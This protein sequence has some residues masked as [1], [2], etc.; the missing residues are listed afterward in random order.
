MDAKAATST[1]LHPTTKTLRFSGTT[2][3]FR[4]Q[5]LLGRTPKRYPC[6]GLWGV[7][8]VLSLNAPQITP[9]ICPKQPHSRLKMPPSRPKPP[10]HRSSAFCFLLSALPYF[11]PH[12]SKAR[13]WRRT[14]YSARAVATARFRESA[15]P[16]IGI[17]MV[18]GNPAS[19]SSGRP[20]ASDPII[21]RRGRG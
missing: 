6:G 9:R 8:G 17:L 15:V 16:F 21:N 7:C 20:C 10:V 19:T 5:N 1:S 14:S 12:P 18:W 3:R 4:P 11:I 13:R 2:G